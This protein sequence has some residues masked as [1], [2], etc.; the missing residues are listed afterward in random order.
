MSSIAD[1]RDY[2]PD[3]DGLRAIAVTSVVLFHAGWAWISG[4]YVG[5]D[6]FFVISGYLIA[7]HIYQE[8]K[9]GR[10]SFANFYARRAK[11]IL[12]ALIVVLIVS[13]LVGLLILSPRELSR[14]GLS[15]VS[16]TLGI[17]NIYF[18]ASTD[19]FAP[20]AD[21]LPLL[22]TWSLGVEEQFYFFFPILLIFLFRQ[23]RVGLLWV[24]A[25]LSVISLICSIVTIRYYPSF[26]FYMLPSRAW[27]LGIGAVLAIAEADG[28]SLTKLSRVAKTGIG[29]LGLVL[30]AAP[31]F[32]YTEN[33]TFPGES[34]LPPALGTAMLIAV[35]SSFVNSMLATRPFTFVGRISYS[36]YL[37][38]WPMLAFCRIASPEPLDWPHA[39]VI[40][41]LSLLAAIVSYYFVE[42][43]FR[44]TRHPV[45]T[46]LVR[47]GAAVA[48]SVAVL[49][50]PAAFKGLKMR[51][52]ATVNSIEAASGE[53][54]KCIV[55]YGASKPNQ[56]E[57]CVP[58]GGRPGIAV[59][60]DS[61]AAALAPGLR[62]V[63][64]EQ[65]YNLFAMTKSSC[66]PMYTVTRFMPNHPGHD[67]Q[68]A[69]FNAA[70]VD[71]IAKHPE[72]RT[73]V[74]TGYWSAPLIEASEG[75]RYA[76][77]GAPA[78]VNSEDNKAI[79]Q[80]GLAAQVKKLRSLGKKVIVL[81][82][83]PIFDVD[84]IA[85]VLR[86]EIPARNL[87]ANVLGANHGP[88][89]M[90]NMSQ[91]FAKEIDTAQ[92]AV[93]AAIL[94]DQDVALIDPKHYLCGKA[95]CEFM[96]NSQILYIDNQ[97]LSAAGAAIVAR[98]LF[99]KPMNMAEK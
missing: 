8:V 21:H 94:S 2:R 9:A 37:W 3:I 96:S 19:Y 83:V 63:V 45:R 78:P 66:P 12:P 67:Q 65:G 30:L 35:R 52:P 10:F 31:I 84:P 41:A 70:V 47:Y 24:V 95:G 81:Q 61:H 22:M 40:V 13:L 23:S 80:V 34:A 29:L 69:A 58:N 46:S 48:A 54:E 14:F 1:R 11:R 91:R 68:C 92:N 43:P 86:Q 20:V 75:S 89:S 64:K 85:V 77:K 57:D 99:A 87:L 27:E 97:H 17:S 50:A 72:I 51:V 15:A 6:V 25:F 18:W 26:T 38:H 74:M 49:V 73:V 36:W 93:N 5:V 33:T 79:L 76:L 42:Q 55:Q 4:G 62:A 88:A 71:I 7:G 59:I 39:T 56:S 16:S 98:N 82:D 60:G 44:Q 53:R 32:I 90:L 28:F